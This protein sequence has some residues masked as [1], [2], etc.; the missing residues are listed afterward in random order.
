[1]IA[2]IVFELGV[3]RLGQR[4]LITKENQYTR[5]H[6]QNG[7]PGNGLGFPTLCSDL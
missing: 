1:M 7:K 5:N 6:K 2:I 3:I 4:G